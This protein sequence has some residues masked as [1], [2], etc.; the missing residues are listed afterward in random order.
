[1]QIMAV[2]FQFIKRYL[3]MTR[4]RHVLSLYHDFQ[5]YERGTFFHLKIYERG[6]IFG[7]MVYKRVR[8]KSSGRSLPVKNFFGYPPGGGYVI[9][10][11]D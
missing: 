4:K 5:V 3:K 7:K 2:L 8:D 1:M 6:T 9:P 10:R 11:T